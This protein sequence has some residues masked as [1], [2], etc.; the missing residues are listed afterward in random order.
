[1][2]LVAVSISL[3]PAVLV[4]STVYGDK[5]VA[6]CR[7]LVSWLWRLTRGK[8]CVRSTHAYVFSN[9]NHGKVVS[10]MET[11][12]LYNRRHPHLCISSQAGQYTIGLVWV[13]VVSKITTWLFI[14]CHITVVPHSRSFG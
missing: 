9:C 8:V 7:R 14:E 1:M 2:W 6:L 11:F 4:A 13:A 5:V 10:V 12:D 3:L